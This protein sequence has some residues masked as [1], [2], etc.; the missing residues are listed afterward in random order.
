MEQ[1]QALNRLRLYGEWQGATDVLSALCTLSESGSWSIDREGRQVYTAP[2][3]EG[4]IATFSFVEEYT[5]GHGIALLP[6]LVAEYWQ[7][8]REA[9]CRVDALP[10][11]IREKQV[12]IRIRDPFGR[13]AKIQ[14]V[15]IGNL[16]GQDGIIAWHSLT[17]I[18]DEEDPAGV[19]EQSKVVASIL[20]LQLGDPIQ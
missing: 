7:T 2:P 8:G 19:L 20:E 6:T 17:D 9:V 14:E 12:F 16:A 5:H 15:T 13:S 18:C 10:K 4:K 3:P 11:D 1:K